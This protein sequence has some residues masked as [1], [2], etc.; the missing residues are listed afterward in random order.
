MVWSGLVWSEEE[1]YF[2]ILGAN[3]ACRIVR[4]RPDGGLVESH[5]EGIETTHR[6]VYE[7]GAETGHTEMLPRR[8]G[9]S[10]LCGKQ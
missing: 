10:F 1:Q 4:G 3:N 2:G 8:I 6:R 9:R 5:R 7:Q